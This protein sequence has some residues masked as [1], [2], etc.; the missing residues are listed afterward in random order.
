MKEKQ[1]WPTKIN[2]LN[3]ELFSCAIIFVVLIFFKEEIDFFRIFFSRSNYSNI[4]TV[5]KAPIR[6]QIKTES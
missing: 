5:Y 2:P 3:S 4:V 6:I 1:D